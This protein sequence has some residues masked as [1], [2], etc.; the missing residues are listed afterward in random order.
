[1]VNLEIIHELKNS[2]TSADTVK[3]LYYWLA[4]T[5]GFDSTMSRNF[6]VCNTTL[7]TVSCDGS[8]GS[9][10]SNDSCSPVSKPNE[11]ARV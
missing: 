11:Y 2:V 9:S 6:F 1:M 4:S 5:L 7:C 8:N 10:C 3:G